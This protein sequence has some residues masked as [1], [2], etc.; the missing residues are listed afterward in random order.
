MEVPNLAMGTVTFVLQMDLST[1]RNSSVA[2]V[3]SIG[4]QLRTTVRIKLD[5]QGNEMVYPWN[6]TDDP[7]KAFGSGFS[8]MYPLGAKGV[9]VFIE[10]DNR[11][12]NQVQS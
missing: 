6:P 3:R 5:S 10:I 7:S 8:N 11:K 12:C 9:I 2:F 4:R 1:F